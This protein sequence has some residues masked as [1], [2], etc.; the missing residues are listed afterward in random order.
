[1]YH[2]LLHI[3]ANPNTFDSKLHT[4]RSVVQFENAYVCLENFRP[5]QNFDLRILKEFY[6]SLDKLDWIIRKNLIMSQ[7]K[8]FGV[9]RSYQSFL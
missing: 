2:E 6:L 7:V 9:I 8:Y 5:S 4:K 1:M 3:I